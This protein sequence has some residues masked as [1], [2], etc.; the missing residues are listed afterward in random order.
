[1]RFQDYA[2]AFI[3]GWWIVVAVLFVGIGITFFYSYSRPEVYE[4]IAKYV[5]SSSVQTTD[6]GDVINSLDTLAAR[7]TVV[8]TYCEILRSKA[9]LD[10]GAAS[11]GL[12][13]LAI[14]ED[15]VV[16]C[17]VLPDSSVMLLSVQGPSPTLTSALANAIGAAGEAYVRS[18]Q[19]VY[20]LKQLDAAAAN[21]EPIRPNHLIDVTLGTILS[22]AGGAALVV[23]RE[24]L[25]TSL[26]P[27]V[28]SFEASPQ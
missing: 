15:Y 13:P 17:V 24:L 10:T 16:N 22:L 8:T 20:T 3:Q 2:R 6:P 7:S 18:L 4:A 25:R 14:A 21:P 19:E 28:A 1:M 12:S 23:L 27:D 9:M 26:K 5:A 11:L